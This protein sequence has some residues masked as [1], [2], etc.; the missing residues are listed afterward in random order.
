MTKVNWTLLQR[1]L[2]PLAKSVILL[3]ELATLVSVTY[4]AIQEEN[5]SS[6]VTLVFF[7]IKKEMMSQNS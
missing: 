7:Q 5:F 2:T 6:S 4:A 1:V 3:L